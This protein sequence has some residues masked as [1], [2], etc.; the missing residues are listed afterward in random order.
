MMLELPRGTATVVDGVRPDDVAAS[1]PDVPGH[2]PDIFHRPAYDL[3]AGVDSRV[4]A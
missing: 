4:V 3:P 1:A 2:Q